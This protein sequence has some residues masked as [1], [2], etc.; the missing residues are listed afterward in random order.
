MRRAAQAPRSCDNWSTKNSDGRTWTGK[1]APLLLPEAVSQGNMLSAQL[2]LLAAVLFANSGC[3]GVASDEPT[4][5]DAATQRRRPS[6][7]RNRRRSAR[8]HRLER[9]LR[10]PGSG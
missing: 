9:K 7:R 8:I 3:A 4:G 10:A 6:H 5:I 2:I 1:E